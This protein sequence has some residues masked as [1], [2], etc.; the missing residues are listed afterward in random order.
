MLQSRALADF[1]SVNGDTYALSS[2]TPN[3]VIIYNE[4]ALLWD[5]F[6]SFYACFPYFYIIF[7][8]FDIILHYC[9]NVCYR[10]QFFQFRTVHLQYMA[11]LIDYKQIS[12]H[13]LIAI[14]KFVKR[15]F[16]V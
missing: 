1:G 10:K 16:S 7:L 6:C 14:W 9:S 3:F 8:L 11:I 5:Q 13:A 12:L 2:I 4:D 15:I